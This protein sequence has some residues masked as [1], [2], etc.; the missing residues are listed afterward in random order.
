MVVKE[1]LMS[2]T[3]CI[4][5]SFTPYTRLFWCGKIGVLELLSGRGMKEMLIKRESLN[6]LWESI[7]V[8]RGGGSLAAGGPDGSAVQYLARDLKVGSSILA[9]GSFLVRGA[10]PLLTLPELYGL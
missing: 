6:K 3:G 8:G 5:T 4:Y 10:V 7:W 9:H 1:H 2:W